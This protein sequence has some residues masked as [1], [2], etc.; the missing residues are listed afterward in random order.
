[1]TNKQIKQL[2][3]IIEYMH[4]C[5]SCLSLISTQFWHEH[6]NNP[7]F[8]LSLLKKMKFAIAVLHKLENN[9]VAY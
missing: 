8:F 1:M 6:R 4:T 2:K 7:T 9:L 5:T 3:E